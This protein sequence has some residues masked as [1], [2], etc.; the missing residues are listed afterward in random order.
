MS[1]PRHTR[2]KNFIGEQ[3]ISH[4]RSMRESTAWRFLPDN[5]RRVLDR[6]ELE[7]VQHGGSENGHLIA[8]YADFKAVGLNR[9]SSISLAIRQCVNLGFVE[10]TQQ[11][12][13]SIS[14]LRW[15][16]RYRL[17]YIVGRGKSPIPTDEWRN[18]RTE[19]QARA[20]LVKAAN[21]KSYNTQPVN[22]RRARTESETNIER[23]TR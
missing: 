2:K 11:G 5:A 8:T 20:A 22:T 1:K 4:P 18:I 17:T 9:R 10:V 23:A 21:A 14:N 19:V 12:G 13:R 7:H 16:S 6:L 15:P 3:F